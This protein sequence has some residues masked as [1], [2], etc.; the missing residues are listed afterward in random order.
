MK[1]LVELNKEQTEYV[2]DISRR[3]SQ[4]PEQVIRGIIHYQQ[5]SNRVY[6]SLGVSPRPLAERAEKLRRRRPGTISDAVVEAYNGRH[7]TGD[8]SFSLA[9]LHSKIPAAL[10][11]ARSH[12]KQLR[13]LRRTLGLLQEQGLVRFRRKPSGGYHWLPPT[14]LDLLGPDLPRSYQYATSRGIS[15]LKHP[16][17]A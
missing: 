4:D 9:S 17:R 15:D 5:V 2:L 14:G 3:V 8:R 6:A 1:I 16:R 13:S 11:R 7:E 12:G 10:W